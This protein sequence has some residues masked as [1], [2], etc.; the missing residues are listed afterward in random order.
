MH[1]KRLIIS[2]TYMAIAIL[3]SGYA[4]ATTRY[5]PIIYLFCAAGFVLFIIRTATSNGRINPRKAQLALLLLSSLLLPA[6]AGLAINSTIENTF[7]FFKLALALTFGA[8]L[9]LSFDFRNFQ[10]TF[11]NAVFAICIISLPGYLLTN[12]TDL[13]DNLPVVTNINEVE[14]KF[15][16]FFI[17][18]DGFLQ[19]RNVGVFWEPGIFATM[20]YCA[21]LADLYSENKASVLRTTIFL[22]ALTSTFSGAGII[23]FVL[24]TALVFSQPPRHGKNNLRGHILPIFAIILTAFVAALYVANTQPEAYTYLERLAG[25]LTDPEDTQSTRLLSPITSLKI[26]LEQPILGWG[27]TGAIEKYR[28][29][30]DE[31]ALTS[32]SAYLMS[33]IGICGI[34][35]TA[36]PIIGIARAKKIN[37]FSRLTL[38]FAFLFIANKEPHIYFTLSYALIFF[39]LE[40][41]LK[42]GSKNPHWPPIVKIRP[43]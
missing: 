35:F 5:S 16:I 27:L 3:T 28:E 42:D 41:S 4:L 25:K 10:N 15:A 1:F 18:F 37:F 12:F 13:L 38:I 40:T 30:N 17:S 39:S 19:Y 31:I 34:L 26:F 14:Y 29:I 43:S 20:I 7:S 11:C 32:S 22:I 21:L 8:V 23:L 6:V 33:A 36:I 24:Y 2:N 9:F